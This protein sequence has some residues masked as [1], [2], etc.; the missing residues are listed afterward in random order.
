MRISLFFCVCVWVCA[1][2]VDYGHINI[3]GF[4]KKINDMTQYNTYTHFLTLRH[5][6]FS[7]VFSVAY[8]FVYIYIYPICIIV[9]L[10]MCCARFGFC[11]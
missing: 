1:M 9:A 3:H 6:C 10:R 2:G 8:K 5:F 7:Y 4:I 11:C